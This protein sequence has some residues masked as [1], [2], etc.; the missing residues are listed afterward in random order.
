MDANN[1]ISFSAGGTNEDLQI[2]SLIDKATCIYL[3]GCLKP[4]NRLLR[5]S[6]MLLVL[7]LLLI[8]LENVFRNAHIETW[9]R[10][11]EFCP[12]A[13]NRAL[14]TCK[15]TLHGTLLIGGA[16]VHKLLAACSYT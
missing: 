7:V 3:E 12:P 16:L 15:F 4:W 11:I 2:P 5:Q 6:H 14:H 9:A 1:S 13:R 8:L 10:C